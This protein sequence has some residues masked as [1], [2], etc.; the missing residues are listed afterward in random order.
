MLDSLLSALGYVGSALDKPGRA[1]R[2]LLAG[3]AREGLAAL[4]FSD[5]LGLTDESQRTSG[6]DLI[7]ALNG[8]EQSPL[9]DVL[10]FGAELA[11]DP[12]MYAGAGLGRMLGKNAEA[13]ALARGPR[14][15]TTAE[16]LGAE[17]LRS[18]NADAFAHNQILGSLE[19][20]A[21][22]DRAA[23][24]VPPGS[25]FLGAGAEG[26]AFE[27][28]GGMVVRMGKAEGPAGAAG[29][30][31]AESVLQPT[32]TAD[33]GYTRPGLNDDYTAMID[34]PMRMRVET[35]P[36]AEAAGDKAF[37]RS[38]DADTM[39]T[40]MDQLDQR[41]AADNIGMWDRHAGN[42]GMYQGRPVAIDPGSLDLSKFAGGY[43]PVAVAGEASRPMNALLNALGSDQAVRSMM[44][45]QGDL[46]LMR[47]LMGY[48]GFA[49]AD[50]G[51]AARAYR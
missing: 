10:G 29:R 44:A 7:R 20:R 50:L 5:S 46:N 18:G 15:G 13:A 33:Y 21:A 36:K 28:P 37:W 25:K 12:L 34:E 4:P 47:R 38:R 8:G 26:M 48:G 43:A 39:L 35:M 51:A 45:G 2:G 17:M 27:T 19:N 40:P 24:E 42:A 31:V 3:N 41:L 30:P 14:Y 9:E 22:W 49:G 1:V 11:T 16:D 23:S 6:S 32:R